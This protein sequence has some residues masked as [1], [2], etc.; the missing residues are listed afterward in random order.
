MKLFCIVFLIL[1]SIFLVSPIMAQNNQIGLLV[2]LNLASVDVES[3]AEQLDIDTSIRTGFSFGGIVYLALSSNI[4]LQFEPSYTQKGS[5]LEVKWM[6]YES[7]IIME[8]T[9]KVNYIDIPILFKASFGQGNTKPYILAGAN[10]S[11]KTGN[12]VV[13][14]DKVTIDGEEDENSQQLIRMLEDELEI[15][16]KNTDFGVNLGVGILFQ[17]GTNQFFLEGQYNIGLKDIVDAEDEDDAEAEIKNKGIQIKV[18]ILF[19]LG[20]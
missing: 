11:F 15:A 18:G 3:Y 2:G 10:I 5:K 9:L 1:T 14:I 8:Q 19:P 13:D 6:T 16:T 4:G 20:G 7:D 17:I 12:A